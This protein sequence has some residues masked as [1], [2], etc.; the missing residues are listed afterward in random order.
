[1]RPGPNVAEGDVRQQGF[2]EIDKGRGVE[3]V[4]ILQHTG[5]GVAVGIHIGGTNVIAGAPTATASRIIDRIIDRAGIDIDI[6]TATGSK[7]N[8]QGTE[9]DELP[10]KS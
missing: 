1:M 9:H 5:L 7:Q 8:H 2:A 10:D 3:A 6:A 4:A